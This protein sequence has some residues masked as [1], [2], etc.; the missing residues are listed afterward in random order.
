[1]ADDNI[2][3]IREAT[4]KSTKELMGTKITFNELKNKARNF[5]KGVLEIY[6]WTNFNLNNPLQDEHEKIVRLWNIKTDIYATQALALL[7]Q[8]FAMA[9]DEFLGRKIILTYVDEKGQ[10]FLYTETGELEILEKVYPQHGRA[11]FYNQ[12]WGT[13]E[14][15]SSLEMENPLGSEKDLVRYIAEKMSTRQATYALGIKRYDELMATEKPRWQ[16]RYYWYYNLKNG[17]SRRGFPRQSFKKGW[18]AEAYVEVVIHD[19][20]NFTND[21]PNVSLKYLYDTY[22]KGKRNVTPAIQK[23]DVTV[24][25]DGKISLAVKADQASTARIGQYISAAYYITQKPDLTPEVLGE[26]IESMPR[27]DIY[28]QQIEKEAIELAS[29]TFEEILKNTYSKV[30]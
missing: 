8:N 19:D 30:D 22:I 29:Q 6:D 16:E 23:G 21:D 13:A 27:I 3:K 28:A 26:W 25:D 1:M 24:G 11:R 10:I 2:Q 7:Q 9:L 12:M 20:K 17:K 18:M 4:I 5:L 14:T 15:F